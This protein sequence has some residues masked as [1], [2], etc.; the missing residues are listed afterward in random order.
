MVGKKNN[1]KEASIVI[2]KKCLLESLELSAEWAF[3][4]DDHQG[5]KS[6][7]PSLVLMR[8][9][10]SLTWDF[11]RVTGMTSHLVLPRL[12]WQEYVRPRLVT[13]EPNSPETAFASVYLFIYFFT[14]LLS[15]LYQVQILLQPL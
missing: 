3:I 7:R 9:S 5:N 4:P 13:N 1:N 2:N 6:S 8:E 14:C 10:S 15:S 11:H 12:V